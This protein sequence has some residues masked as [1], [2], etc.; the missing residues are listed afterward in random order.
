MPFAFSDADREHWRDVIAAALALAALRTRTRMASALGGKTL[1]ENANKVF[2]A[3]WWD[4]ELRGGPT[5]AISTVATDAGQKFIDAHDVADLV[6]PSA[7]ADLAAGV[8]ALGV[9]MLSQRGD[10]VENRVSA[11]IAEG[12]EK[13]WTPEQL[14][15]ALGLGDNP[16]GPLSDALAQNM[17]TTTTTTTLS[18]ATGTIIDYAGL[19]GSK[20]WNCVFI[21][22]RESHMNAD[23]QIQPL[24]APFILEGGE[25][26]FP[27][28]PDLPDDE[29]INCL[30]GDSIVTSSQIR[31]ATRRSY[32]GPVVRLWTRAGEHLSVTP[33]HPVLTGRGWIPA[34]EIQPGRDHVYRLVGEDIGAPAPGHDPDVDHQTIAEVFDA[35]QNSGRGQRVRGLPVDFHGDGRE[36]EVEV[37]TPDGL[38][39]T[40]DVASLSEA[41]QQVLF[42]E[43][44]V[45]ERAL[46]G[47][48]LP[49]QLNVSS[50]AAA[51]GLL[52]RR[53]GGGVALL[54]K[55]LGGAPP[56]EGHPGVLQAAP[57]G[58]A[59]GPELLGKFEERHAAVVEPDEV[60]YVEVVP[61][62]GHVFNL[63]TT[64]G[65]YR[66]GGLIVHN[67]Q[68]F[69]TYDVQRAEPTGPEEDDQVTAS[70]KVTEMA[71]RGSA[72]FAEAATFASSSSVI[73]TVEPS[74]PEKNALAIQG[75][76]SPDMLHITLANLGDIAADP[77][78]RRIIAGVLA[79]FGAKNGPFEGT[80]AG[81]G[82][83]QAADKMTIALVD[84]P[85]LSVLRAA[86]V[87]ALVSAGY[88][89]LENHD[90]VAHITLANAQVDAA[91]RVGMT[92]TFDELRLRWG[93]E[94]LAFDL[95]GIPTPPEVPEVQSPPEAPPTQ[96]ASVAY[97]IVSN[98]PDCAGSQDGPVAVVDAAGA[99]VSCHADP[100]DAQAKAD[101]LNAQEAN[102]PAPA[103]PVAPVAPPVAPPVAAT[104]NQFAPGLPAPPGMPTEPITPDAPPETAPSADPAF[105]GLSDEAIAAELARR[106]AEKALAGQ[107]VDD[108]TA[109]Q[110]TAQAT[111]EIAEAIDDIAEDAAEIIA[112]QPLDEDT[113]PDDGTTTDMPPAFA[114]RRV[115]ARQI[116]LPPPATITRNPATRTAR[117]STPDGSFT[118]TAVTADGSIG[119]VYEWEG[120]LTVEGLPSGDGRLIS[121]GVLTWRNLPIPLMLQT[122]NAPGHDGSVFCGWIH[123]VERVGNAI[124]GRGSFTDDEAGEKARG[125]L[126][127][128]NGANRFGV[129]VDI[130]SVTVVFADPETGAELSPDEAMFGDS[131]V[132]EV[133]V[134]GRIMGATLTP[135]PAF[136]E[137]SISLLAPAEGG[138]LDE[139]IAA[140]INGELW[141]STIP[142][143]FSLGGTI[144]TEALVASAAGPDQEA[145]PLSYFQPRPMEDPE[146]FAV[147]TPDAHGIIPVYGLVA[148]D[149][150]CH[151]GNSRRCIPVPKSNDFR[152]FYTGKSV[153]TR[154]G[155]R[156]PTGPIVLDTVHP[157]LM[158]QASDAQAFYAK[159]GCAVADV[160]LYRNEHGI[161]AAG[162][163]RPG[164]TKSDIRILQASDISPDWR[165]IKR[166]H[167]LVAL[168]ACNASGFLVEGI[169]ASAGNFRPWGLY[170]G[171]TG[172]V[173]ALVAAGAIIRDRTDQA[174]VRDDMEALRAQVDDLRAQVARLAI[175]VS[176]PAPL[177]TA[178]R[179]ARAK[180]AFARMGLD[181]C[182]D[183]AST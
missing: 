82:W 127:D 174:A 131:E 30:V 45:L 173:G 148:Q 68:C 48:G 88:A 66:A 123:E 149:G 95:L 164:A 136:Q 99:L 62:H 166:E 1:P 69:L 5:D 91:D 132:L 134:T 8:A 165:P 46:A 154:E 93:P 160:A 145:P 47:P 141:R 153:T 150:T 29:V 65:W 158:A 144:A 61:Y 75:G 50:L 13:G 4:A 38:L 77:E 51:A 100:V 49:N 104:P 35:A 15:D 109:A 28:D 9:T 157:N 74:P 97:E 71:R 76:E 37:Q 121:E 87:D 175:A 125:I 90:F 33:N 117:V 137:A 102:P 92:I 98:H 113:E 142:A 156:V 138:P 112:G 122:I 36:A 85:G 152:S 32:D 94:V 96:E 182:E 63:G 118:L 135:F 169:A 128:P 178:E 57:D 27:G 72:W 67:C 31:G 171:A 139:A 81:I 26:Q 3:A 86:I 143:Q 159:T 130:D 7:L 162:V 54:T 22:S 151:I 25:G 181:D 11:L 79:S 55:R 129:S 64:T 168:L 167:K 43:A 12:T 78:A 105:D 18:S 39:V 111:Q 44:V 106:A 103:P 101:E 14:A 147:G 172:E 161:V 120:V 80:V 163:M 108:A 24:D 176:T 2:Q 119:P 126:G 110:V 177:S 179:T 34:A 23:G 73:V 70:V 42:M 17:A 53:D 20:K 107:D 170:D 10:T 58:P 21:N 40:P 124:V 83:F 16:S 180:A 52:G 183:C 60:I 133:L 114:R 155:T 41:T 89:P 140:S 116:S 115:A 19:V 146:P 59:A 84:S 6:G 56:T